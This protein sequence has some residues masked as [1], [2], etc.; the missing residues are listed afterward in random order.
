[1][2]MLAWGM[3]VIAVLVLTLGVTATAVLIR[4]GSNSIPTVSDIQATQG[5]DS[6]EFTWPD[7]GII[8]GDSYQVTSDGGTSI[9]SSE[10]FVIDAQGGDRVCITV[11]VNRAGATG[12]PSNQKCVVFTE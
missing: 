5:V 3:V 7:P 9:Q 4:A 10:S 1:M 8:E 2:K 11:S 6:I 12:P